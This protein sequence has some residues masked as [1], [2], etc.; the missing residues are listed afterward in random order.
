MRKSILRGFVFAALASLITILYAVPSQAQWATNGS[1]MT[2]SN[3]GNIGIGTANPTYGKLQVNKSIRIDDDSA[4]PTGSDVL[5]ES[6]YL[7]I[8][9]TNGGSTLQYNSVGGL[10]LWLYNGGWGRALSFNRNGSFNFSSGGKF[11]GNVA[12]GTATSAARLDVAGDVNVSGNINAKYQDVAEWV[13]STEK[14]RAGTVVVLD[15]R[16]ANHVLASATAY[17]TRVAGVVSARPGLSLGEAGEG[18]ALVATTGRVKVRVNA[19]RAPIRIGDLLVTSDVAGVA[20]KSEPFAVGGRHIHAPGT[21]I[22][23][24][25]EPL[26]KGTGEILV[27]LSLQ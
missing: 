10:D 25:L 5:A 11:G 17:D 27:L 18:K 23:K 19:K 21:I 22:G 13:P 12:I 1:N 15:T 7:Y 24:A 3:A 14:L 16:H 26:E 20:M 8:G 6:P 9:T 4:S 2:S